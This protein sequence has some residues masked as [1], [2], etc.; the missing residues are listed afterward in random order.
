MITN[1]EPLVLLC[2]FFTIIVCNFSLTTKTKIDIVFSIQ[3]IVFM[4]FLF[5]FV[6]SIII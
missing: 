1:Y 4:W 5:H 3:A 2:I 6:H